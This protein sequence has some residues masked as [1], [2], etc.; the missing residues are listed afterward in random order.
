MDVVTFRGGRKVNEVLGIDIGGTKIR[1]GVVARDGKV[2]VDFVFPTKLPLYPY[3]EEK[4][5]NVLESY[6]SIEG[7][8]IGTRGMVKNGVVIYEKEMAGWEGTAVKSQLEKS[9]GIPVEINNDANCAAL[10]EAKMGAA[11]EFHHVVCLTL[12]TGLGAGIIVEGQVMNGS[13]GGAGEVGHMILYPNGLLCGCGRKG[14]SEQY[15]SGT[16]IRRMITEANVIDPET[17]QLLSPHNLFKQAANGLQS[18]MTIREQFITDLSLVISSL[19][20]IFDMDCVV[21]SGGVSD[22]ADHWWGLLLEK[23]REQT[24]KPLIIRRAAFGNEAGM[25]GAAMLVTNGVKI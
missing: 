13:E 23:V 15:V 11:K 16:A 20:A 25:L 7:I 3:L 8:G 21:I 22:S 17:G 2:V 9:T 6:P 5:F 19:Q 10:A 14:C 4:I 12:G 18:A 1:M 24:L